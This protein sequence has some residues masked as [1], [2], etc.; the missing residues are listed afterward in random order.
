MDNQK[1][2]RCIVVGHNANGEPDLFFVKVCC[3]ESE[4]D[5]GKHYEAAIEYA[6]SEG[7]EPGIIAF[8]ENDPAGRK[9]LP[10]FAWNTATVIDIDG[11]HIP[12]EENQAENGSETKTAEIE[13]LQAFN[14]K[15]LAALELLYDTGADSTSFNYA[16]SRASA[17]LREAKGI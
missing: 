9:T 13:R 6:E 7:Y 5:E 3:S 10:L 4:Y 8:D 12:S 17:V 15:L 11:D 16:R 1:T 14:K 2:L